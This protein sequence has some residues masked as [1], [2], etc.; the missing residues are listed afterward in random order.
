MASSVRS[1]ERLPAHVEEKEDEGG[2]VWE[3]GKE[4]REGGREEEGKRDSPTQRVGAGGFLLSPKALAR[5]SALGSRCR[6]PKRNT[7]QL[8]D[9]LGREKGTN[10]PE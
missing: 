1:K 9:K 6:Y 4:E 8:L 7:D 5:P 10:E 3:D 2:L